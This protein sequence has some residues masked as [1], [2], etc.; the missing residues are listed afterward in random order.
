MSDHYK[1]S[2]VD[3][4]A[5]AQ[6]V[7]LMRS[8]VRATYNENVLSDL[9]HFGGLFSLQTF[10]HLAHP[11][12]VSS[13]DG[14]GTK[15]KVAA[16]LNRWDSIGQ[17]LV[18]HCINDILVQGATPLFF[19]D[20][21]ASSKLD[22][23]Q[24]AAIVSGMATA[25]QSAHCALL[26]GETAEMPGVYLD[27]EV[28][29]VGT[30][31]GIVDYDHIL[32]GQRIQSSDAILALPSNG[33]HTNGYTL[34][35]SILADQDWLTPDPDLGTSLGDA[36]LAPHRSYLSETQL[37]RQTFDLRGMA[38]IT[39]GGLIDNLPRILPAGLAAQIE[40]SAWEI[41]PLFQKI[42]ALG[43]ID[44]QE[45]FRVFNMGLG[46]LYIL[47]AHQQQ[48]MLDLF[49]ESFLIGHVTGGGGVQLV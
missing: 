4:D 5:G 10:Q 25:C 40:L 13:T 26:G 17:D 28:D 34:A 44:L 7:H 37:I 39:G 35:R 20:Y 11:V 8:A 49:P 30:I 48:Q 45:M 36:L 3:I 41:P 29:L 9:G 32:D 47:P 19:L 21:V 16:R 23:E 24:I 6:A 46:M 38:H 14:V 18:N 43:H 27:G 22:P 33:L 1:K 42:Q 12:L 15:T 31:V 2:G